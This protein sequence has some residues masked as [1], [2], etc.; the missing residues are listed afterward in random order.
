[1]DQHAQGHEDSSDSDNEIQYIEAVSLPEQTATTIKRENGDKFQ[2]FGDRL[3]GIISAFI[4]LLLIF[5]LYSTHLLY[6]YLPWMEERTKHGFS[7]TDS[8]GIFLWTGLVLMTFLVAMGLW[9]FLM[10]LLTDNRVRRQCSKDSSAEDLEETPE[11][12]IKR[13][14]RKCNQEKPTRSHHCSICNAC[15]LRMD[16]HC[17]WI[18]NCVGFR[19]HGHYLRF[20][21][22]V[23]LAMLTG[24]LLMATRLFT[25]KGRYMYW[26]QRNGRFNIFL[27]EEMT[28]MAFLVADVVG[29][30]ILSLMIGLLLAI[31]LVN[32]S[33][34]HTTIESLEIAQCERD[35]RRQ[36]RRSE[37]ELPASS[38]AENIIFPFDL[39]PSFNF[40][41]VFGSNVLLWPFPLP[42]EWNT[43]AGSV[44]GLEFETHPDALL[45]GQWPLPSKEPLLVSTRRGSLDDGGGFVVKN[46]SFQV[47]QSP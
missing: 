1:M 10:A 18:N 39:G 43:L 22:Y 9:S 4:S 31:Q 27:T 12:H 17:P 11:F 19:N 42:V 37:P 35:I 5:G 13:W 3:A 15:V 25:F 32:V 14:C 7:S 33:K 36:Q 34:G 2:R 45:N 16:H 8:V 41:A 47:Y 29:C 30:G 40:K 24:L 6:V 20:L 28:Q 44:D 23:T 26:G 21:F 38:F 46:K